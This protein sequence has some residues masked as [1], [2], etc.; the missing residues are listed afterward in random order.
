[1]LQLLFTTLPEKNAPYEL[2]P[3][4]QD[5]LH[6]GFG[7]KGGAIRFFR[8]ARAFWLNFNFIGAAMVTLHI[9]M[10]IC[11]YALYSLIWPVH[12]S[13]FHFYLLPKH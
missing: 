5:S 11:H 4:I 13:R 12:F 1:L 10:A 7:N 8:F 6:P 3:S 2:L 9:I